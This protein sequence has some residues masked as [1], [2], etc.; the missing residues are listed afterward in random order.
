MSKSF[1]YFP[2]ELLLSEEP[3]LSSSLLP[4]SEAIRPHYTSV[5]FNLW[6]CTDKEIHKPSQVLYMQPTQRELIQGLRLIKGLPGA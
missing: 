2:E 3:L 6:S 4:F 5:V 1:T